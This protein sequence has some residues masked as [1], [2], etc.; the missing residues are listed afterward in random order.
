[1]RIVSYNVR[2]ICG[3]EKRVIMKELVERC[4]IDI[5]C[6]QET[7]CEGGGLSIMRDWGSQTL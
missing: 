3:G 7:K 5:L 2:G 1:M 6:L 4:K